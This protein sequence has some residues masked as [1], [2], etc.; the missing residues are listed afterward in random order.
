MQARWITHSLIRRQGR[1]T[2]FVAGLHA[3][4][5]ANL[6]EQGTAHARVASSQ[7][8]VQSVRAGGSCPASHEDVTRGG[9]SAPDASSSSQVGNTPREEGKES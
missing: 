4:V 3:A 9:A 5:A 6:G 7:R 8:I 2:N 1:G